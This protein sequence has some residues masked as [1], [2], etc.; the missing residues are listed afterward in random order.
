MAVA[1]GPIMTL[2]Q[3]A[4]RSRAPSAPP[5]R[6]FEPNAYDEWW[7][8]RVKEVHGFDPGDPD[9]H[10]NIPAMTYEWTDGRAR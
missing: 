8:Q 9:F 1:C 10:P 5:R 6:G 4:P 3:R 2:A 7:L